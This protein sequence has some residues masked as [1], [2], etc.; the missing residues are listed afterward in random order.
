[1]FVHLAPF[2]TDRGLGGDVAATAAG[3]VGAGLAIS[4]VGAGFIL[5]RVFAPLVGLSAFVLGAAGFLLLIVMP[6]S[7]ALLLLSALLLGVSTGT[8]GDL[9]PYMARKYFG[10]RAHSSTWGY[11]C[12]TSHSNYVILYYLPIYCACNV[13]TKISHFR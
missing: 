10:K 8:E 11:A 12:G 9:I 5:D 6:N 2:A 7:P 4:R 3:I 13:Q 1:M